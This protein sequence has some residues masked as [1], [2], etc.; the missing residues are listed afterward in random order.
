MEPFQVTILTMAMFLVFVQM[1]SSSVSAIVFRNINSW[2]FVGATFA[3]AIGM[4]F[5]NLLVLGP[6]NSAA[7]IIIG[8]VVFGLVIGATLGSFFLAL[9]DN[10]STL[11]AEG[12]AVSFAVTSVITLVAALIG[13]L[14]G[15]NF[16]GLQGIMLAILFGVLIVS[17][18]FIFIRLNRVVEML[19]GLGVAVFFSIYMVVD[20]N[21]IVTRY[22]Q[23][24]WQVANEVAMKVYLDFLNILIRIAPYF[25]Q[26]LSH[27]R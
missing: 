1:V 5:I 4:V 14:S 7:L 12:V 19:F 21:T 9:A 3:V 27:K 22:H 15:Y 26:A 8:D 24:T 17:V 11:A 6:T 25:I 13:L 2:F 18:I 20:F 23:A 10:D 16:Q